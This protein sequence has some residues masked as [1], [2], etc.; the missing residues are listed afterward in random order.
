MST[1]R[2]FMLHCGVLC[3][4]SLCQL[5]FYLL[6][7]SVYL[8]SDPVN[9]VFLGLPV[10]YECMFLPLGWDGEMSVTVFAYVLCIHIF[11]LLLIDNSSSSLLSLPNHE[12][13]VGQIYCVQCPL[14]HGV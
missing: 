8:P 6:S 1:F 10:S 13:S 4:C 12:S 14:T 5:C 2:S 7:D 11:L 9:S 3:S